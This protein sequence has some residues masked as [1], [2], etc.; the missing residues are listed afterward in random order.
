ME[1][2]ETYSLF[3]GTNVACRILGIDPQVM[4]EKSGLAELAR[5]RAELRGTVE[6]Y[7]HS[8]NIMGEL[9]PREVVRQNWTAC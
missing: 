2:S 4:L 3:M 6:Q 5:G 1:N 8:W 9:S 7:F